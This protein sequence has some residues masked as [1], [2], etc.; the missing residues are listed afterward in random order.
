MTPSRFVAALALVLV[1]AAVGRWTAPQ[2]PATVEAPEPR[3]APAWRASLAAARATPGG[4]ALRAHALEVVDQAEGD[5]ALVDAV[6]LLGWAGTDDD[7]AWLEAVARSGDPTLEGVAIEALGRIGTPGAV[8]VLLGLEQ[9]D[10]LGPSAMSAL[11][12]AGH[13]RAVA[14]LLERLDDPRTSGQAAWAL[15]RVDD[16]ALAHRVAAA[17]GR[18]RPNEVAGLAEALASFPGDQARELL[19]AELDA[20]SALRRD[21]ALAALARAGDPLVLPI[22]LGDLEQGS[23]QRQARA[24]ASLGDYGDPSVADALYR[25][26]IAGDREVQSAAVGSLGRLPG[27]KARARLLDLIDAGPDQAAT[28]AVWSL[29]RPEDDDA[30]ALLTQVWK[31]RSWNVRQAISWRLLDAPWTRGD[32]P[33]AVLALARAELADPPPGGSSGAP[34]FLLDHG[35]ADD[36]AA[37]EALLRDGPTGTRSRIV[38]DLAEWPGPVAD[39]MLATALDDPDAGVRDAAVRAMLRRGTAPETLEAPLVAALN[40][41]RSQ[42]G[43]IEQLLMELGTPGGRAAVE[44]RLRGG[45]T[46][47]RQAAIQALAWSGAPEGLDALRRHAEETDDPQER[48]QIVQSLLWSPDGADPELAEELIADGDPGLRSVG[49]QALANSGPQGRDR[50]LQLADDDDPDLRRDAVAALAN[51]PSPEVE[52]LMMRSLDDPDLGPNALSALAQIG[53]GAA[54]AAVERVASGHDDPSLR[55]TA[56]NQLAWSGSARAPELLEAAVD[57]DDPMVRQSAV[58]ALESTGSSRSA[59]VLAAL[60]DDDDLDVARSAAGALQRVGGPLAADHADAIEALQDADED[61][62][63]VGGYMPHGW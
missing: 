56:L 24:A 7:V 8:D 47:E 43:R 38:D 55:S 36:L 20:G 40:E 63:A 46:R 51:H 3:P 59:A 33:E 58:G 12:S 42:Y 49:V 52:A 1:G 34:G 62:G 4:D 22:L 16:P 11:G 37:V 45:T 28:Q 39:R 13:P 5:A 57:D 9:D 14:R 17:L 26:V 2:E 60:L 15:A 19:L 6:E 21:A 53:S 30:V 29:P 54:R 50:L 61:G 44:A 27:K 18:A 10:R 48:M 35:D 23:R 41:G 32:V 25:A 31:R